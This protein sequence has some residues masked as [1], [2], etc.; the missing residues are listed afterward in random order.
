MW[1]MSVTP[2]GPLWAVFRRV[3]FS[4]LGILRSTLPPHQPF[5]PHTWKVKSQTPLLSLRFDHICFC[6]MVKDQTGDKS[7]VIVGAVKSG[8]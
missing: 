4:V 7:K 1:G 3:T 5:L 2:H 8:K 6:P